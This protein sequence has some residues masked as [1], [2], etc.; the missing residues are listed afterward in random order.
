VNPAVRTIDVAGVRRRFLLAEPAGGVSAVILSLHGTRSSAAGQA[1]LSRMAQ[2]AEDSGA[3]VAF[4]EAIAPVGSGFE[5]DHEGDLPYLLQLATDLLGRYPA[6]IRRVCVVGMSGGA[7]MACHFAAVHPEAV[8]MV[9][10]VAGLRGPDAPVLS[11]PVPVLAFHGLADRINPYEGGR[12]PRW[13]ESVPEAARRWA[14]ANGV[15]AE[16]TTV[17]PSATLTRTTYGSEGQPGEVTL[18]TARGAGHTWPGNPLGPF[19]RLLLGRTTTEI[20]AT[21]QIWSFAQR[22][23]PEP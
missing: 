8:I 7:R 19:L 12:T 20:D 14:L 4:P 5:W 18:W 21:A 11:R 16:P 3:V 17:A 1:R 9:G 23:W 6:P 22:H 15:S 13:D 2:L 10:A